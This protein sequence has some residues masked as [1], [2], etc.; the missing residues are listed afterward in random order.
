MSL[1]S[2]ALSSVTDKS[3]LIIPCDLIDFN[4][5]PCGGSVQ[6]TRLCSSDPAI[7]LFNFVSLAVSV[8]YVGVVRHRESA[9]LDTCD[10][11]IRQLR[12]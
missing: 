2:V 11:E 4:V 10:G 7:P 12:R 9:W 5:H 3:I 1:L 6:L 8:E